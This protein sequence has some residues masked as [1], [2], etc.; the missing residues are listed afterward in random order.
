MSTATTSSLRKL[1]RGARRAARAASV[2][3]CLLVVATGCG[4]SSGTSGGTTIVSG[5]GGT[6]TLRSIDDLDTFN[7]AT[8]GAPNM[9]VQALDL[10]YDRLIYMTPDYKLQPYLASSWDNST[11]GSL[12][13][14][15]RTGATCADGTPVTPTVVANSLKYELATSTNSPYLGY[16]LGPGALKSVTADETQGTVTVA[17][18]KPYNALAVVFSTPFPTAI[19]CPKGVANPKSLDTAPDGSGPY[20]LDT[21]RTVRGSVY[22]FTLRKNYNW[23]PNGWA[24]GKNG[25][26]DTIVERIATD[27]TTGANLI[28]T[29]Q[30]DIAPVFG[31]NEPR[32]EANHSAYTFTTN[33]LQMGSWGVVFNQTSGG[34]GGDPAI[35]HAAYLALDTKSMIQAAFS[36][37]GVVFNTMLTPNMRCYNPAVGSGVPGFDTAQAKSILQGDGY[38]P[39]SDGIM[40]KNG[41][42][43]TLKI[44]MWN[45]T[46]QLGDYMQTAL[47]QVGID[48]TV[49][50]TDINTW[51]AALFTTRDYDLTVYSY[52]SSIPDPVIIPAQDASLSIND[53]TYF[54]LS[55]D[56]E[57]A[58][59]ASACAAWDKA[60]GQAVANYDVKPI[61]VSK[62]IWFGRHWQFA[63][64]VDVIVD[65][66]TL[67]KTT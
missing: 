7:P 41:K 42:K 52:Y 9:A 6:V 4:T 57:M 61:G 26:P 50:I 20:I 54:S 23:G 27:E 38:T 43:L 40:A 12:T 53:P 30:V 63:A 65:P 1:D 62:N 22:Y 31:I 49:N 39:G 46:N 15:I 48:S 59:D 14:K 58:P 36:N 35:R 21:S 44:V 2:A 33:S 37:A 60:L 25:I 16:V 56:A 13:F 10:A 67:E 18:T 32:V 29:G 24:A 47:K 45:T 34:P 51:I 3:V 66:F 8:T 5:S 17:L 19:I 55:N 28:T 11:P 64:P